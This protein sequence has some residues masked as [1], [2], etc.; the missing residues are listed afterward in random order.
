MRARWRWALLLVAL[1]PRLASADVV[2]S[3]SQHIGDC[4]DPLGCIGLTPP[5]PQ[6]R[7]D[8]FN[9]LV[10]FNLTTTTT[11]TDVRLDGAVWPD[12]QQ[13]QVYIQPLGGAN[14]FRAGTLSGNTY[15]L[16][17][18]VVLLPGDYS[19]WVD[20][21]CASSSGGSHFYA[22]CGNPG[23]D[24]DF[25]FSSITLVSAQTSTSRML[26]RRRHVGD[27]TEGDGNDDNGDYD[28]SYYP[29][30][31]D[32]SF[33]SETFTLDAN[34]RLMSVSFYSLRGVSAAVSNTVQVDGTQVG[35]LTTASSAIA[36]YTIATN[37][38]LTA[39]SHTLRIDPGDENPGA[40]V[41]LNDMSW[42]DVVLTFADTVASGTPGLFN[43]VNTGAGATTGVLSTKTAGGSPGIDIVA[44]N[45]SAT[46][47]NTGYTGLVTVQLM[48]ASVDGAVDAFS[49][50]HATW[51]AVAGYATSV[52][53]TAVSAG[54]VA[55][56]APFFSA[57]LRQAALRMTDT[58]TGAVA[59]STDRFAL[60]PDHF[61]VT[62]A[63]GSETTPGA[64]PLGNTGTGGLP[65]HKAGKPFR[66]AAVAVD[67]ANAA[68]AG[69]DGTLDT[70]HTTAALAPA[71]VDG[72]VTTGSWVTSGATRTTDEAR[73]DEVGA[74]TLTLKDSTF[75]A[76]DAG[77][78]S[79]AQRHITGTAD[80]GRFIPDHFVFSEVQAEFA[81]GC[82]GA[83]TYAGQAF[84]YAL[85]PTGRI[86]AMSGHATPVVTRNY[87]DGALHKLTAVA[88]SSFSA[89]AG[90]LEVV[91]LPSPDAT[92]TNAGNG[93]TTVT[94]AAATQLRFQR[95][96]VGAP[97]EADIAITLGAL[98]EEDGV[99]FLTT[100]VS[101][102]EASA[103]NGVEFTGGAKSVRFGRL[104][105]DNAH[106]SE[107]LPLAVPLRAEYWNN[108]FQR[109]TDD[110]CTALGVG[111]LS[112]ATTLS[113]ASPPALSALSN[114]AWTLTL[115]QNPPQA[116][117]AATITAV[118]GT[119]FPWL[120][121]DDTDADAL[122]NNNPLGLATFGL[123][124][125][126]DRRIFQREV[127]GF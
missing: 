3:G 69:Y 14:V 80:V 21:G 112:V 120:Q 18:S 58:A 44:L 95:T 42:D 124:N 105:V 71:T 84:G 62:A 7:N 34:R 25:G 12:R 2:L 48:D 70:T 23:N 85:V 38:L 1:A 82:S 92:L 81:P 46:A 43:A 96:A 68:L 66:I 10:K 5:D 8:M 51:T 26:S 114:G 102:G 45:P 101:F 91:A 11:I 28:G 107:N 104:V 56:P 78:S 79:D 83:F 93:D 35:T 122:Y 67:A 90:T 127:V 63:Q 39:G 99:N 77:D 49:G 53:F 47:I 108:G 41:A 27:T 9:T 106:G 52:L 75:A 40:P 50:C 73:Y 22:N 17:P 72:T 76:V 89:A 74:F 123:S 20:G 98:T 24:N 64:S 119:N 31:P 118:L 36:P 37:V 88:P 86:T 32:G 109:N 125:D 121:T 97:F 19:L 4:L 100:P 54:R 59:C 33:V 110:N 55:L 61:T 6:S 65:R 103:G 60:R 30:A 15:T 113:L 13:L 115:T 29:D 57:T 117:G 111:D 116:P 94:L 16:S 87:T 126:Q